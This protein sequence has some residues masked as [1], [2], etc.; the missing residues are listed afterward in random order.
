MSKEIKELNITISRLD[1]TV[2]YRI[3]QPTIAN[4]QVHMKQL[5]RQTIF[6]VMK[7]A[8]IN[9][10]RFK[11]YKIGSWKTMELNLKSVT[12]IFLEKNQIF[13]NEI[14]FESTHGSKNS[15]GKLKCILNWNKIKISIWKFL[16][17]SWNSNQRKLR[18]L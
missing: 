7:Q 3:L 4:Y 8:L 12:K 6:W 13:G 14:D 18:I 17:C 10:K 11:W 2:I 5:P 9:F 15:K 16:G 1:L